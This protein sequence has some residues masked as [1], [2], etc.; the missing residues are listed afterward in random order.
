LRTAQSLNSNFL[1]H[2]VALAY[3]LLTLYTVSNEL[4]QWVEREV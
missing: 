3:R 1:E 2:R 4:F